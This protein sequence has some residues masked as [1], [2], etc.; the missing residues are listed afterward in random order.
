MDVLSAVWKFLNSQ[1]FM[2][3]LTGLGGAYFGARAAQE[4][5]ERE[6]RREELLKEIRHTN[7]AINVAGAI[8]N[9]LLALKKQ[10]IASL[11]KKFDE[12]KAAIEAFEARIA[13]GNRPSG[14]FTFVADLQT[15][16]LQRLPIAILQ[17]QIFEK[18]SVVGRP[19]T[20]ATTLA[21]T[22]VNLSQSMERRNSLIELYKAQF[23]AN[24]A[25]VPAA[26]YFGLPINGQV[27]ED[28]PATVKHIHALTDDVIF[29]SHLLCEDLGGH[30]N[31]LVARFK[32]MFPRDA[33]PIVTKWDFSAH[34]NLF[35]DP[36]L[37]HNWTTNFLRVTS[38]VPSFLSRW[39]P[40]FYRAYQAICSK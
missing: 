5:A 21:E 17:N 9:S 32:K 1:F 26:L 13:A 15:L 28:Y 22:A 10:H 3:V 23:M 18:L 25:T 2:A 8:C 20:L 24:G 33:Q 39:F 37:F 12:G 14:P 16:S 7:A 31:D 40:T 38:A 11:K 27:N 6:K 4:I 34:A 19:L 36:K 29:F 35:P 30:G